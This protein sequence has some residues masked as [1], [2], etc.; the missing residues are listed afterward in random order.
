MILR[1]I[2]LA[3]W[4]AFAASTG[5]ASA[6]SGG[7]VQA[8]YDACAIYGCNGDQLVGVV[9]CETGGTWDP[10]V[11]GPN[12]ERGLFQYHPVSHNPAGYYAWEDPYLQIQIAA[13]DWAAGLGHHWVCQGW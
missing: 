12:G 10:Y 3:A 4:L 1:K 13:Q 9:E 11:I 6:Q 8:I 7:Y 5:A 2:V